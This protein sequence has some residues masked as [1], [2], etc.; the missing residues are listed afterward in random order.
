MW[1]ICCLYVD[2]T[3]SDPPCPD[4]QIRPEATAQAA[5]HVAEKL[6][7]WVAL[8]SEVGV[9]EVRKIPGYHDEP[10]RGQRVVSA[11]CA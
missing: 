7:G 3:Y 4:F 6:R 11:R 1:K 10:L 8:V 9:E 2:L 5:N